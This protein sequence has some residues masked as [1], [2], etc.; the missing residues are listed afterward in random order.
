MT[1]THIAKLVLIELV[2]QMPG[3]GYKK[4]DPCVLLA[5][6]DLETG[7][8]NNTRQRRTG[9]SFG[10]KAST[11]NIHVDKTNAD[12]ASYVYWTR[13]NYSSTSGNLVGGGDN[14]ANTSPSRQP[15][16][17][18]NLDLTDA[19]S[20]RWYG[21]SGWFLNELG[22]DALASAIAGSVRDYLARQRQFNIPDTFDALEYMKATSGPLT[23]GTLGYVPYPDRM[24]YTASWMARYKTM[25]EQPWY[26]S[27]FTEWLPQQTGYEIRLVQEEP[28]L[29][30][31]G[32]Q[33]GWDQDGFGPTSEEIAAEEAAN[34]DNDHWDSVQAGLE[35]GIVNEGKGEGS[36]MMLGMGALALL[37][38]MGN[39]RRN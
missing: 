5:Q 31:G 11:R 8:F 27:V 34:V 18:I 2:N 37:L 15:S 4:I 20:N 21:P 33:W 19:P 12:F 23:M 7:G 10:M 39:K 25:M 28:K 36:A 30:L 29:F 17:Y 13:G 14:P 6:S 22:D 35:D 32:L 3:A 38:F 9:N 1:P 16:E 24:G 26:T